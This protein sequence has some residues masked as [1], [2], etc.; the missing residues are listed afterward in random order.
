MSE[1]NI[2]KDRASRTLI[3]DRTFAAPKERVWRA[4]TTDEINKWWGPRGW[5]TTTKHQEV[6][7][8]GYWH[9]CMKCVDESQGEWFGQESCGK[10]V[11]EEVDEPNKFVYKD[12]FLDDD[13]KV[14]EGMPVM[15]ITMEFIEENGQTRVVSTGVFET[16]ADYDTVMGMGVEQGAA[17]TWD[18]LAEYLR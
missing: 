14:K 10:A 1:T 11:F 8:G 6:K 7:T 4:W 12:Y 16:E 17:E 9:Y 15:T 18:R 5:E 13:G 2:A 3:M